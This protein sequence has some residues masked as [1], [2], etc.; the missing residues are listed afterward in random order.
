[1]F[2]QLLGHKTLAMTMRY[3]HLAPEGLR[4]AVRLVALG[5]AVQRVALGAAGP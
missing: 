5:G 1:M 2:Q 3:T 4:A